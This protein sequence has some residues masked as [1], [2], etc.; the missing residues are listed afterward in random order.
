M[1]FLSPRMLHSDYFVSTL[2]T[3]PSQMWLDNWKLCL[4]NTN[5]LPQASYHASFYKRFSMKIRWKFWL[6]RVHFDI[7]ISCLF[8]WLQVKRFYC[9]I[10]CGIDRSCEVHFCVPKL[11]IFSNK[12]YME[13]IFFLQKQKGTKIISS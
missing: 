12:L 2:I 11:S 7:W 4:V 9:P 10:G 1:S 3:W 8:S 6:P 13:K 5:S